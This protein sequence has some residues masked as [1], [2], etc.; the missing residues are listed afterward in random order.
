MPT[1]IIRL[2][3]VPILALAFT[4]S[5]MPQDRADDLRA[6]LEVLVKPHLKKS[7]LAGIVVG[8]I[9]KGDRYVFSY[10]KTSGKSEKPPDGD[11][12]FEIGSITKV[13]TTLLL[14]DMAREGLVDPDDPVQKYLPDKVTMSKWN[15]T[16]ITLHHLATHTSGLPRLPEWES[17]DPKNPYA[18][19]TV[20]VLYAFLSGHKLQRAPGKYEYSNLGMGLL[21]HVLAR[22]VNMSYEQLVIKRVCEPLGMK[23]TRITLGTGHKQRF[24]QGHTGK[25]F[26]R[27]FPSKPVK[28]WDIPV[29][30]GA[31]AL[32]S[33]VNDML[34]FLAANMG[35]TK[36]KLTPIM[37]RCHKKQMQISNNPLESDH[38]CLGWHTYKV[39][40]FEDEIIWHDGGTRGYRSYMG[41]TNTGD[42]GVIVLSNRGE[43]VSSLGSAI[44]M[45]L[46]S[47]KIK[48]MDKLT[49]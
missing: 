31:G 36:T 4:R 7:N 35:S 48:L 29:L 32:R 30:E 45:S 13:F 47:K 49:S 9:D 10:G 40:L 5:A 46:D 41:F 17:K 38:I 33:T 28:N 14:M 11:T 44:L 22:R 12:I 20:E 19:P 37:K 27:M 39:S 24:A 34:I 8:I 42:Y 2:L 1:K 15:D 6:Q 21:G 18:D 26:F 3:L 25:R 43:C 23:D 16:E